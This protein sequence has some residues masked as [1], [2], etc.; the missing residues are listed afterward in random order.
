MELIKLQGKVPQSV[1][2]ELPSVVSKFKI[3]N[4][5]RLAHFL[6]QCAHESGNFKIVNENLNYGAKGL[7]VTF[8]K[9]FPTLELAN[10]YARQPEKIANKVYAKRMGN[11]DEASG[12][13]WKY[14]GRGYIQLTGFNNYSLFDG[15]VD[16]DIKSNPDLVATKYPL[17]SAAWFWNTNSINS[18][19]SKG[20]D[21]E[22][23]TQV[24]KK[25][26]G[27]TIGLAERIELTEYFYNILK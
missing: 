10:Q 22:T 21:H 19:A 4:P 18:I 17:L 14:K 15:I 9:Y 1:I 12:M 16:D 24:S 3:D 11:G 23:I 5:I 8:G 7:Q 27:G 2:N 25:I 20:V 26:N 6:G 13:G